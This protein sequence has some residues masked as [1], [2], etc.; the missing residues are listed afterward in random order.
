MN[1]LVDDAA[2]RNLLERLHLASDAQDDAVASWVAPGDSARPTGFE[3]F[4]SDSRGFYRDKFVA[5][6]RDKGQFCYSVCR[7]I[8]AKRV[9]EAGTSF[10]VSTLYLASAVRDN[11]GGR[12]VATEYEPAKAAA[13]LEHFREAGIADLVELRVGD[14]RETLLPP[15]PPIDFVLLDIW[16][17]IAGTAMK[18]LGPH[19]KTGGVVI[20]DN[21]VSRRSLYGELIDYLDDPSNGFTMQVL[22]FEGGLAFA[23]KTGPA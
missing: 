15:H 9:V 2:I 14:I 22:P 4:E 18:M 23:V 12:V 13:A 17:P 19:V 6:E 11:G 10:G 5:I 7:A 20:A 3:D 21:I 16:A 8:A 1:S